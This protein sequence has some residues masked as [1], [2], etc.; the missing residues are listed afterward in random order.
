MDINFQFFLVVG[1]LI[2]F[3]RFSNDFV[4]RNGV[5]WIAC[6]FGRW[7]HNKSLTILLSILYQVSLNEQF[8]AF[9]LPN[10]M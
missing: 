8:C 2:Y 5:E 10:I 4:K 7:L 6:G 1:Q 9:C 3:G